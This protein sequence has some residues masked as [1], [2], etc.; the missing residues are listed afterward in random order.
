M[1]SALMKKVAA[2]AKEQDA[3]RK[4]VEAFKPHR[5]ELLKGV[6]HIERWQATI[7]AAH[8]C[9]EIL[10]KLPLEELAATGRHAEATGWIVDPT[11]YRE[12][13][14]ALRTDLEVLRAA[15]RFAAE[16]EAAL[17]RARAEVKA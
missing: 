6:E 11:L 7:H 16:V 14:P 10:R 17:V 2:Q 12:K 8:A 9:A 1:V 4:Q 15:G 13:A 3:Q 5:S